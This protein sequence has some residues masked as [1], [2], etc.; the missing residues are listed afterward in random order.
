MAL[1]ISSFSHGDGTTVCSVQD[2]LLTKNAP[3][4]WKGTMGHTKPYL[5][6]YCHPVDY[7]QLGGVPFRGI[8]DRID[9]GDDGKII[10]D[11]K[12]GSAP[13]QRY[14]A[15]KLSQVMLYA[16]AVEAET[17]DRPIEARL[18]YLGQ[19]VVGV[20]VTEESIAKAVADLRE[21]WD[22]VLSSCKTSQFDPSVGPL[23]GWCPYVERCQTGSDEVRRRVKAG[24]MRTDAP[25]VALVASAEASK[26]Q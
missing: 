18:L 12:S 2:N 4:C 7:L 14:E 21:I 25:A 8:V 16:A 13:Q 3:P 15:D 1:A 20:K 9:L 10:S 22:R 19:R 26:A 17:G 5:I 23:C 6:D 11:Y 24:R